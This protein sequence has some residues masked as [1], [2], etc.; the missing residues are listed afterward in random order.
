M[1]IVD[2]LRR[3]SICLSGKASG[4]MDVIDYMVSLMEKGGHLSDV[5]AYKQAVLKREAEGTTGIGEGVAIPHAKT[6][7]VL[8]PG[9]AAM[10][11]SEGVEFDS[12]DGQPVR[13]V[14][15]I[16]APDTKDN[17]HLEVLSRLSMLLMDQRFREHLLHAKSPEAFL[18]VIDVAEKEKFARED[19][20][21][22]PSKG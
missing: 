11:F 17:V 16:G 6:D 9:L 22:A 1:K 21:S 12:L 13:L 3:D 18:K 19:K 2:L 20:I 4:K 10:T 7:A 15:M 8:S 14:F 5:K